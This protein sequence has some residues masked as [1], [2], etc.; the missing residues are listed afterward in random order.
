MLCF[1]LYCFVSSFSRFSC[2]PAVVLG[3]K[4]EVAHDDADL[5]AGD[6]EDEHDGHQEAEDEVQLL[7]PHCRHDEDELYQDGSEGK[8]AGERDSHLFIKAY[9]KK[10]KNKYRCQNTRNSHIGRS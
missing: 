2:L 1:V 4:L 3:A 5:G 10:E 8:D 7:L 9:E 6:G